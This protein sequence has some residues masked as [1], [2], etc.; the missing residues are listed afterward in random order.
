MDSTVL[1]IGASLFPRQHGLWLKIV[2][3]DATA[4]AR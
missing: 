2:K 4:E 1:L 3:R